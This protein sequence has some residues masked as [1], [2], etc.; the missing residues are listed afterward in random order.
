[1][2][3]MKW[4]VGSLG[5]LVLVVVAVASFLG[6]S[7]VKDIQEELSRNVRLLV[8]QAIEDSDDDVDRIGELAREL[9]QAKSLYQGSKEAIDSLKVLTDFEDIHRQDPQFAY[10]RL[11]R[12][13]GEEL[14]P[15]NRGTALKL[16]KNLVEAGEAGIVDP[17]LLFNVSVLASRMGFQLEAVQSAVLADHWR[18]ALDHRALK[19]QSTEV[20]G[21]SFTLED[22][23]LREID[24]SPERIREDAWNDLLAIVESAPRQ[25]SQQIYSRA[26]NVAIR[27]R[28]L[29]YFDQ[30]IN[31]IANSETQHPERISSYALCTLAALYSHQSEGGW[32][33]M[34]KGA[35]RRSLELL[36]EESPSSTWYHQTVEDLKEEAERVGMMDWLSGVFEEMGMIED[37]LA[38]WRD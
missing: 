17:T 11:S 34:Y 14:T 3:H 36:R 25:E 22:G 4:V 24:L 1:M 19:A 13:E 26:W 30:L 27:N 9:E 15:T 38:T 16:F 12:L 31:V 10:E 37:G 5:S 7:N 8:A 18:P 35:V 33:Q 6:I 21:R 20:L 32:R 28:S 29:G 23:S 2:G